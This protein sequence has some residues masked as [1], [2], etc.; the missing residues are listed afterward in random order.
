MTPALRDV[1]VEPFRVGRSR[2]LGG[3]AVSRTPDAGDKLRAVTTSMRLS[4]TF[5]H[6]FCF[7]LLTAQP[8]CRGCAPQPT[9][10]RA[11]ES[12]TES[13]PPPEPTVV[14]ESNAVPPTPSGVP[15]PATTAT[16]PATEL[17]PALENLLRRI[18]S[19][20]DPID[21]IVPD[22]H[23]DPQ[24]SQFAGVAAR[25]F[26]R[27]RAVRDP[28]IC[29]RLDVRHRQ[30]CGIEPSQVAARSRSDRG[31]IATESAMVRCRSAGLPDALCTQYGEAVELGQPTRC[32]G[33]PTELAI[34]CEV[35]A[36][37]DAHAC[38]RIPREVSCGQEVQFYA[39]LRQGVGSLRQ[40]ADPTFRAYIVG[41]E[42]A[43][44]ACADYARARA[45]EALAAS[46]VSTGA[47][48]PPGP[49]APPVAH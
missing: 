23:T 30:K 10:G 3:T 2:P 1:L 36:S 47:P 5:A 24:I 41:L 12:P 25:N 7:V 31:W 46:R 28:S 6:G 4:R 37:G 19:T 9:A 45:Q 17:S 13:E 43:P 40:H 26:V 21:A 15:G 18:V 42:A 33:L 48:A 34:N 49:Q 29:A 39:L 14:G 16:L 38:D 8:A 27:C 22:P 35:M 11:H 20:N 44:Q 32:A